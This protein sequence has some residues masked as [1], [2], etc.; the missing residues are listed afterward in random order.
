[1]TKTIGFLVV[2]LATVAAP[3]R[4]R[5]VGP[6]NPTLAPVDQLTAAAVEP[7]VHAIDQQAPP[8]QPAAHPAKRARMSR[9]AR[10]LEDRLPSTA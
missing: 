3:V 5:V 10:A 6:A 2:G 1:M 4:A 7:G 8:N 9:W